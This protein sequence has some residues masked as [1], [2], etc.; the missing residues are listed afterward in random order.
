MIAAC[1]KIMK[2]FK[3]DRKFAIQAI[4][5]SEL[6]HGNRLTSCQV[7]ILIRKQFGIS[8]QNPYFNRVLDKLNVKIDN[9]MTMRDF[10]DSLSLTKEV[11]E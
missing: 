9:S 2:S 7:G 6:L 10:I 11:E 1:T 3:C 5:E 8:E 4:N